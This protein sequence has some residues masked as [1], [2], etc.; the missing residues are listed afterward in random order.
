MFTNDN[1][2]KN[3]L[4]GAIE[5]FHR[6]RRQ[7]ITEQILSR[8]SG[9]SVDALSYEHVRKLLKGTEQNVPKLRNIP[10]E[11][12]V[13]SVGRYTDFTRSFHPKASV[14]ESRWAGVKIAATGL[15][16]LPPIEVY[17]IGDVYF[18]FDGNHR[19]S[20]AKQIGATHIEAYVTEVKA[21][22][23]LSPDDQPDDLIAKAEYIQF[24]EK[25]QLDTLRPN[26][27][28]RV[29]VPGQY[30]LLEEH[31]QIHRYFL[32]INLQRDISWEEA[33]T[34]WYDNVYLP[35]VQVIRDKGLPDQFPDRT[36]ADFYLWVSEYRRELTMEL[37]WEVD[38]KVAAAD[39]VLQAR[40][41]LGN[42]LTRLGR[43]IL[44]TI[45]ADSEESEDK[46]GKQQRER[47][48]IHEDDR[49]FTEILVPITG[50]ETSWIALEQAFEIARREGAFLRGMHVVPS[51]DLIES[52]TSRAVQTE[53]IQR[54][55]GA[56]IPG[57]MVVTAGKISNQICARS[58]LTD[59]IIL[60]L[61]HPPP[62]KVLGKLGSGFR[63]IV[64]NCTGPILAVPG[65]ASS[66]NSALL[67]YDGSPKA[68]EALF[69]AT[70]I[71]SRWHIPLVV[72]SVKDNG[73]V[74]GD[75]LE[76]AQKYLDNYGVQASYILKDRPVASS[77]LE[78]A[79]EHQSGLILMGGYGEPPLLEIALGSVVNELL[80]TSRIPLLICH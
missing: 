41:Q 80:R 6:A 69:V 35:V 48:A 11:A 32:G 67:A 39:L 47:M 17:Q 53:F 73:R 8:L 33:V 59:L 79:Q 46:P 44:K 30:R 78:T 49:L 63:S 21:R 55:E 25:T 24:L 26:A 29:T 7:A 14:D 31:I 9:K 28:L 52:E 10:V 16:G 65:Q 15:V 3:P 77:I 13:G 76:T 54:C 36:E 71:A 58:R 18:V 4:A 23:A 75:T 22:V 43:V 1:P 20:V 56:G 72:T 66:V 42:S 34:N 61:A 68:D 74:T 51:E 64:R 45:K 2:F 19:V 70:H 62:A 50:E 38:P 60:N 37:G 57:T 12:I 27:D 5:D 40:S